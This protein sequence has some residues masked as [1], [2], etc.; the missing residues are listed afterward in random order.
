V[1]TDVDEAHVLEGE[2]GSVSLGARQYEFHNLR[3][4]VHPEC[5]G[6]SHFDWV[7]KQAL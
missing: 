2:V 4:H 3:G 5:G 6:E 1:T 7:A